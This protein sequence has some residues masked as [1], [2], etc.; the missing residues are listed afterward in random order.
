MVVNELGGTLAGTG[1]SVTAAQA[2]VEE[3]TAG[4]GEAVANSASV[5][6][7]SSA[8]SIVRQAVDAFGRVD[9]V[10]N[11]AGILRDRSFAKMDLA[12]FDEVVR[13]HLMGSV[14]VTRAALPLMRERGYG[15]IVLTASAS[16]L[17][18]N[19]GQSSYG[20]A[21]LALVGLMNCLRLEGAKYDIRVNAVSP[22]AATR[23]TAP[24]LA[25]EAVA[26]LRPELVTPAV[27]FLC[28]E[29][30]PTGHILAAG[31]AH[32]A[33]IEILEAA[34]VTLDE[35]ATAEDVAAR[36]AEISDM[37]CPQRPESASK[38]TAALTARA[39]RRLAARSPESA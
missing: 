35:S 33:R 23:M 12:D 24:L 1:G 14:Y 18:G 26:A 30:C 2:G 21:K 7:L 11:N 8:E 13:A 17:F 19:F 9:V 39:K 37:T 5:A 10:L 25:P 22:V 27:V 32:F 34:G 31:G 36:Y 4:G 6:Q 20:A 29:Q 3:I 28:S 15:R 38:R 16:G